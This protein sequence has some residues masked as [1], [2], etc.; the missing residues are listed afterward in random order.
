MEGCREE[1]IRRVRIAGRADEGGSES[2]V[3]EVVTGPVLRRE[4]VV[5]GRCC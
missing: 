3:L 2:E 5:F 4:R 1:K